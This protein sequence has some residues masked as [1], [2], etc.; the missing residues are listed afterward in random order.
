MA[1][2]TTTE[3]N[4]QNGKGADQNQGNG[5]QGTATQNGQNG[6]DQGGDKGKTDMVPH[7][8]FHAEREARKEAEKKLKEYESAE[9]ERKR[10]A[11]EEQGNFKKLYE[12]EKANREKASTTL[13]ELQQKVD[14]FE[15]AALEEIETAI[16]SIKQTEDQEIIRETLKGKSIAEQKSILPK[17]LKKFV[18]PADINAG[19]KGAG[20]SD[21]GNGDNDTKRK[22]ALEKGNVMEALKYAPTVSAQ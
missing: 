15:K 11:E 17:L 10:K 20:G 14:T 19:P 8:A 22:A 9:A 18:A 4:G 1:G 21:A 13:Q 5:S 16:K 12:E 3:Q 6:G 7:Q 2:E